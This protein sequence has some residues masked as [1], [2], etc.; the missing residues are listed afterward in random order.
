MAGAEITDQ[1]RQPG[2]YRTLPTPVILFV[3]RQKG[4]PRHTLRPVF[5]EAMASRSDHLLPGHQ[6][7][8]PF[9]RCRHSAMP[10]MRH[11]RMHEHRRTGHQHGYESDM[12]TQ[13]HESRG[14][15]NTTKIMFFVFFIVLVLFLPLFPKAPQR[16]AKAGFGSDKPTSRTQNPTLRAAASGLCGENPSFRV[17]S[18]TSRRRGWR[19]LAHSYGVQIPYLLT[20]ARTPG[21]KNRAPQQTAPTGRAGQPPPIGWLRRSH[22]SWLHPPCGCPGKLLCPTIIGRASWEILPF[23]LIVETGYFP[24]KAWRAGFLA[25]PCDANPAKA[26][27]GPLDTR[28]LEL[29]R[30]QEGT[31]LTPGDRYRS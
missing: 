4:P 26:P 29:A 22:S 21:P 3:A 12:S 19:R 20:N 13:R 15:R 5:A 14:K 25:I 11:H 1:Y 17:P 6:P 10:M 23:Q 31:A 28:K 7:D 24:L 2:P 30:Q 27:V 16:Y 8:R 18:G 9:N